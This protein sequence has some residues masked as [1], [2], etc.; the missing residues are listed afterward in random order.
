MSHPSRVSDGSAA[1]ESGRPAPAKP[2]WARG[3]SEAAEDSTR[4]W[5]GWGV[6]DPDR[7][8]AS[9]RSTADQVTRTE[10]PSGGSA[11]RSTSDT[12]RT[13]AGGVDQRL[14]G[15]GS[16]R[17]LARRSGGRQA[18]GPTGSGRRRPQS[19][20][21]CCATSM[22]RSARGRGAFRSESR[23]SHHRPCARAHESWRS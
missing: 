16:W 5:G 22:V 15:G 10:L 4:N 18:H 19:S 7:A 14:P 12:W 13:R 21:C 17:S 6:R 3:L 1:T 23:W 2:A 20:G 8:P 9:R 11:T